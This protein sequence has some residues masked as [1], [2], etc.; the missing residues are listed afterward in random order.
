M[1]T[2]SGDNQLALDP[3]I[4]DPSLIKRSRLLDDDDDDVTTSRI[5]QYF[6]AGEAAEGVRLRPLRRS[7][8][9]DD[10]KSDYAS[11]L[12]QLT[13]V[14]DLGDSAAAAAFDRMLHSANTYYIV[15][16]ECCESRRLVASATLLVRRGL[17]DEFAR[18]RLEDV[19]VDNERRRRGYLALLLQVLFR[20][21]ATTI[22]CEYVTLDCRGE[23][24]IEIYRKF[25]FEKREE[26]THLVARL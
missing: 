1:S 3:Y 5:R 10:D 4:F 13:A 26:S 17:R 20:L 11:L 15:V 16:L 23:R 24:L 18:G 6:D 8:L 12:A 19:V 14:G 22:Q 21:A 25:G 7:D 2:E 9:L